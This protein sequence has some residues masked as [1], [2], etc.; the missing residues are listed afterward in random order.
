MTYLQHRAWI[1]VKI[2]V[3]N[4]TLIFTAFCDPIKR[5]KSLSELLRR[6]ILNYSPGASFVN[7]VFQRRRLDGFDRRVSESPKVRAALAPDGQLTYPL[8]SGDPLFAK[9]QRR[10]DISSLNARSLSVNGRQPLSKVPNQ[11][12]KSDECQAP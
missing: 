6:L 9:A 3:L 11:Y 5:R 8:H 7:I 4:L 2:A 1:I 12:H 10:S